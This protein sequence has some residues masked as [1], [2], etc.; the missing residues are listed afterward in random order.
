MPYSYYLHLHEYTVSR[1][2]K[3][4]RNGMYNVYYLLII[5]V[6]GGGETSKGG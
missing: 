2:R 3:E 4:L 1:L 6:V 5:I